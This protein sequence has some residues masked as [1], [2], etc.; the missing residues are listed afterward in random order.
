V[1]RYEDMKSHPLKTFIK[2]SRFA[3][4]DHSDIQ[5]QKAIDF[6]SFDVMQQQE[7]AEGFHEKGLASSRFFRKGAVGSWRDELKED[8]A[9]KIVCDHREVMRRFGYL[10][11]KG[12]IIY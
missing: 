1:I 5:I 7:D 11:E 3:G 2:A 6:S 10:D 9:N 4:L 12:K 8:Q